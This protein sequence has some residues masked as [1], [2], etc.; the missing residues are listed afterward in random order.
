MSKSRGT[1]KFHYQ[2]PAPQLKNKRALKKFLFDL[3]KTEGKKVDTINYIFCNDA[4]LLDINQQYLHHDTYTDI[5]TFEL[6]E[7][8]RPLLSDIYISIERVK[9]NASTLSVSITTELLRV[10]FHGVLH[11]AGYK[12]KS[13]NDIKLMR[14]KEELYLSQFS[15][16][17]ETTR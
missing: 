3:L 10:V 16:S 1:I 2:E 14:S 5:I 7:P 15:V 17:R 9:E 6:N 12:D 4:F 8:G 13:Q 11:L